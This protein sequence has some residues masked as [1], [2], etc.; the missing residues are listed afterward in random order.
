VDYSR[1]E[2]TD[3]IVTSGFEFIPESL[4]SYRVT[5]DFLLIP[6]EDIDIDSYQK[7]TGLT[8]SD[9]NDTTL[10]GLR[11]ED[12]DHPFY[13]NMFQSNI[14]QV[15]LPK[16]KRLLNVEGR[17][18]HLMVNEFGKSFLSVIQSN[19]HL[20]YIFSSPLLPDFTNLTTHSIF[21]PVFY[22]IAQSSNVVTEPIYYDL[23]NK[24]VSFK[25]DEFRSSDD[26]LI[27]G[28]GVEFIPNYRYSHG[29]LTL[30][31]PPEGIN[32][33]HYLIL[34]NG[35][36]LRQISLNYD[37]DESD[38]RMY[39][40][41]ELESFSATSSRINLLDTDTLQGLA[42]E[43]ETKFSDHNLM[44]YALVLALFFILAESLLVRFL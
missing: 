16:A 24:S 15:N 3:L 42:N 1:L 20:I 36:T 7:F 4:K 9:A 26:I 17:I 41:E 8:M 40:K 31:I 14:D 29:V 18:N 30:E 35:D 43:I 2:I 19:E 37:K 6:A 38:M 21:L 22:K 32:P 13:E 44:K 25:V 23:K 11:I 39:S 5:S 33:G 34:S 28:I 27:Q 10:N 12:I